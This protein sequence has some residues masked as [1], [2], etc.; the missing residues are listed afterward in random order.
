VA[1]TG[2]F[3]FGQHVWAITDSEIRK[4]RHDPWELA[5]RAVQPV[6]WL[7]V[8]GHV[9]ARV[10][11]MPTGELSYLEF[12]TPGI[13]AQSVLFVAIFYGISVIW[14]KDLGIL[15]KYLVSPAS[16]TALV[17]GKGLSAGVRGLSG[18]LIVYVLTLVMEIRTNL[19]PLAILGVLLLIVL[20]SAVFSTLSLI[21][22]CLVKT[23]ERFMGMG[24]VM[25]MP[26]FFASNAIY[27]LSLMPDWLRIVSRV[28]P[29]TYQVDALRTLML[30][31]GTSTFG[32]G[33]DV[34]VLL[35][36]LVALVWTAGRL[37]PRMVT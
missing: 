1:P 24:Q 9:M 6:L 34:S 30:P 31:G 10:R 3:R 14:E 8:F 23:R 16:R 17:L 27:P 21:I 7:V 15:Q 4:L 26:I 19:H 29:L 35:A 11:G 25:T 20:G 18:A 28:N 36:A 33:V 13:L 12:M 22:A 5:T 32:L 2:L 37:Y